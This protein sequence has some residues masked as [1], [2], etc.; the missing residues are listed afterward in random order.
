MKY[1]DNVDVYEHG[2]LVPDG[3]RPPAGL[4]IIA[5]NRLPIYSD[6]TLTLV[7]SDGSS[8]NE[9]TIHALEV[10][11]PHKVADY[12]EESDVRFFLRESLYHLNSVIDRYVI[13]CQIFDEWHGYWVGP[14]N[15]NTGDSRFLFE[16]DAYLG[17]ARRVYEAVSKVLWKHFS[18]SPDGKG[19]WS[20]MRKTVVAIE[21]GSTHIPGPIAATVANS[22]NTYGT[23]LADYR[24]YVAHTGALS[25]SEVCWMRRFSGR[26]GASVALLE[27]PEDKK[28]TPIDPDVRRDALAYSHDVA[29]HLVELCEDLSVVPEIADYLAH[30]PGYGGRPKATRRERG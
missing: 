26:W 2:I 3:E 11:G 13:A 28:R 12:Y 9:R 24:N 10:P 1:P 21:S 29:T 18:D 6:S 22:W 30:P 25:A 16:I 7:A 19:R 4:A 20:S 14:Q 15:G 27:N 17:A 5:T 23:T 8:L